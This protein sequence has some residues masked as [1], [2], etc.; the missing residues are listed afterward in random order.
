MAIARPGVAEFVVS[1]SRTISLILFTFR[2]K[3]SNS[4][5]IRGTPTYAVNILT[6][7]M[8]RL[9]YPRTRVG[10]VNVHRN[11]GVCRALLAGR[12]YTRTASVNGFCHIPYSGHSLGCSGCFG[13]NSGSHGPLARFGSGGARL[14]GI[15]RMGRGLLSLT[16]VGS[17]LTRFGG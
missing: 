4:V 2:G 12:R 5:L 16:C 13:S 15:R 8:G 3:I 11:R 6:R 7:T 1:L 17:R 10:I 9:F 14:L